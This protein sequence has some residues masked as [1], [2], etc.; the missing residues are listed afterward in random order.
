MDSSGNIETAGG[1]TAKGAYAIRADDATPGAGTIYGYMGRAAGSDGVSATHGVALCG[2]G[3]NPESLG[4]ASN[5]I[6][7]TNAGARMQ[8]G[9]HSLWVASGGAAYDGQEI[10]TKEYVEMMIASAMARRN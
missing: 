10:A 8:A 4:A 2:P 9:G 3:T 6:I 7:V 1:M 5:Y